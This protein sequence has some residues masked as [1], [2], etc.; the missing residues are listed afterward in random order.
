MKW[1]TIVQGGIILFGLFTGAHFSKIAYKEHEKLGHSELKA[2]KGMEHGTIDISKDRIIPKIIDFKVLKD[3]MS[4]W[5]VYVQV[6]NFRFAPENASQPHRQG[7]GHAHLYINGNK[8]A[9][10]YSNWFHIP[11]LIKD[12]NEIKVTL[13]SNDHQTLTIG[14]Q[15][16]EKIIIKEKD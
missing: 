6:S 8:I 10:L 14:K 9:R 12:K 11:E 4:G 1:E 13:N 5:N 7:E 2:H 16:I 3:P 15:A